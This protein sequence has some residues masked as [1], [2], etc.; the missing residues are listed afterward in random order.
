MTNETLT[1]PQSHWQTCLKDLGEQY[2]G[3]AVTTEVLLGELGDQIASKSLP[4][5]GLS[6]ETKGS[7]KGN[8]LVELGDSPDEFMIHH[9]HRPR[10]LRVAVSQPGAE[11]DVEIESE[12][13]TITILRLRKRPALPGESKGSPRAARAA[14]HQS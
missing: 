3:W 8:I 10:A 4:L 1:I 6:L 13:G 7:E 5:Q 12:D 14:R 11:T 2:V 9:V